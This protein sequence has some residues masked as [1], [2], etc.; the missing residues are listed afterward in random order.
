[1]PMQSEQAQT[2]K[3]Y[4]D[5]ADLEEEGRLS[6]LQYCA[7]K[8][9]GLEDMCLVE[10]DAPAIGQPG[11]G[12]DDNWFEHLREGVVVRK[13]LSLDSP[14]A[15]AAWLL[16]CGR[17]ATGNQQ[18]LHV[19]VNGHALVR[20]PSQVAHP[21]ARQYYSTDWGGAHFDNWFVVPIPSGTLQAGNNEILLSCQSEETAWEIMLGAAAEYARGSDGGG[22][23]HP[24]RS[25]RSTDGGQT[26]SEELGWQGAWRGEYCIRLSL[27]S[28]AAAG[29]YRSP[30]ID[31]AAGGGMWVEAAAIET[32]KLAWETEQPAA[33]EI[34]I[35]L[36]WGSS[37]RPGAANWTPWE[38][39]DG[40]AGCWEKPAGRYLQFEAELTTQ[41]P[42]VSPWLKG[43]R[44]ETELGATDAG[45]ARLVQAH[46]GLVRRSSVD[47][48]H[49]D[50][51]QLADLRRRFEL[52]RVVEG[53]ASEFAAQVRLMR[54][55]YTVPIG[56]LDRYRWDYRDLP[57]EQRDDSGGL[58]QQGPYEGR[59]RDKHC[60]Y[61][62]LTLIAACISMGYPA[63]WVNVSTKHTYGHEVAEVWSNDFDKWVMFDAT[64]DYF[65]CDRES[66]LPLNLVE[67]SGRLG[68]VMPH[69]A[70]WEFPI[71]HWLPQGV[72]PEQLRVV[73]PTGDNPHPVFDPQLGSEDLILM[74]HLQ[75]PLRSDFTS[76]PH[77]LPWRISSN[78]GSDQFYCWYSDAFPRKRE[79]ARHTR[80]WQDYNPAL[81]QSQ[82]FLH[83]SQ[84]DGRL[85]VEVDTE[86][87][88]FEC[89]V[90]QQDQG[91]WQERREPVW[92]WLLHPGLNS[93]RVKTRNR[94]GVCGPEARA[95]VAWP[96]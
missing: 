45:R 18:P 1:M 54:W 86:T 3:I 76:R 80:R 52:D 28:F 56:D 47:F 57:L 90:V 36:R 26:W 64:R 43:V 53:A 60:L 66:G 62:N 88:W 9:I 5:A 40:R 31:A 61:C 15:Q 65:L 4:I 25:G 50:P 16:F 22:R 23:S 93:L 79:Y 12:A 32:S 7:E 24:G 17:E 48:V 83:Q 58:V 51:A 6:Q 67:I 14:G 46:N 89:F 30:V 20:L 59:R 94:M 27:D 39:V 13:E 82:L 11:G 55:A 96:G 73:S 68:A 37:P 72:H 44:I 81:N 38:T 71:Q 19:Q 74:G 49:E 70:T 35:R 42:L 29:T 77:P 84:E 2:K 78:W 85:Q 8:G 41:D 69:P 10:D 92:D 21:A 33:T 63:R 75:M 34:R 91:D 87:P 95:E